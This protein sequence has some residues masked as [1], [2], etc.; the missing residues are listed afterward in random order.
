[1]DGKES[2]TQKSRRSEAAHVAIAMLKAAIIKACYE[3]HWRDG[4]FWS[5]RHSSSDVDNDLERL[6]ESM[7]TTEAE[8]AIFKDTRS[9]VADMRAYLEGRPT[10]LSSVDD[11]DWVK[12]L[13][14]VFESQVG[15]VLEA[16]E[17]STVQN[18]GPSTKPA[19]SRKGDE[20]DGFEKSKGL[21][22]FGW[23]AEVLMSER[24]PTMM[25]MIRMRRSF[26]ATSRHT[27]VFHRTLLSIVKIP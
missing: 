16:G 20:D 22:W 26:Y 1:M 21:W 27:P 13:K 18:D 11:L 12:R 6:E 17:V 4:A 10:N 23:L 25:W 24:R 8:K 3:N 15:E 19:L 2:L 14:S 5:I 9:K 7:K